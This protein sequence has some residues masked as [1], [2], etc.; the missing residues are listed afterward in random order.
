MNR[1]SQCSRPLAELKREKHHSR[2]IRTL[3]PEVKHKGG[4]VMV[5]PV[6]SWYSACPIIT[7]LDNVTA[8]DY[9]S[10]LGNQVHPIVQ[11]LFPK[12]STI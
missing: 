10:I 12:G 11:I 4:F 8:R 7:M 1:L 3:I 9:L 5:W 6:I 2:L